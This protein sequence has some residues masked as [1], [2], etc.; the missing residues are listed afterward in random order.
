M[1]AAEEC[2]P[3]KNYVLSIYP[4]F[5]R[6]STVLVHQ[7]IFQS[8]VSTPLSQCI[9]RYGSVIRKQIITPL[10]SKCTGKA[11]ERHLDRR[12]TRSEDLVPRTSSV[13]IEIDEDMD[14]ILDDLAD[15]P[16]R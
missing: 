13:A 12:W 4:V 8:N 5:V 7:S 16:F 14:A 3:A 2:I 6:A 1:V 11:H 10:G 9:W 15:K